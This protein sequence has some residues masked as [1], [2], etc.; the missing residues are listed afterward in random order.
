M[1]YLSPALRAQ[2][3]VTAP[4]YM[5]FAETPP[6]L[7]TPLHDEARCFD[8]PA[9][10]RE[11]VALSLA[12]LEVLEAAGLPAVHA[13]ARELAAALVERLA[14]RGRTVAPRGETTLVSWEEADPA[15][16]RAALADAG[17]VVRDLPG[18]PYLRASVGAW[19]DDTDLDRLLA[20][21]P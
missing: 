4:S 21:L 1:L 7:D 14:A 19:N 12:A 9:L 16:A 15:A 11:T 10:P 3:R 17:V 8:T 18:R 2:L 20:A 13:R 6:D 5:S